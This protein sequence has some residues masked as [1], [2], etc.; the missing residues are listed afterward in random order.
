MY[1]RQFKQFVRGVDPGFDERKWG[2][3][4]IMEFLRITQREGLFRLERDRRGQIRVFPGSAFQRT[5]TAATA[6]EMSQADEIP[7]VVEAEAV[8]AA[9][10]LEPE[11]P[12]STDELVEETIEI[13]SSAPE[14]EPEAEPEPAKPRRP[15]K[16]RAKQAKKPVRRGHR[17]RKADAAESIA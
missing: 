9:T 6:E 12:S 17:S 13:E 15:R 3:S 2:F 8:E 7:V 10:P 14:P 1:V 5:A 11:M 16:S 4:T